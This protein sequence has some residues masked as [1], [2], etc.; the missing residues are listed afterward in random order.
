MTRRQERGLRVVQQQQ[1]PLVVDAG[2]AGQADSAQQQQQQVLMT[3][4]AEQVVMER[5][6]AGVGDRAAAAGS[7]AAVVPRCL[8]WTRITT[9]APPL[10]RVWHG[11]MALLLPG[12]WLSMCPRGITCLMTPPRAWAPCKA[13][14]RPGSRP[15]SCLSWSSSLWGRS[16]CVCLCVCSGVGA[17]PAGVGLGL[18]EFRGGGG[19][20][21]GPGV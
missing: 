17:A 12:W 3:A 15:G 8:A 10:L 13:K 2:G 18:D 14:R 1:Q 19:L 16:A 7:V 6:A 11:S 21:A 5:A 9:T 20:W 4:M